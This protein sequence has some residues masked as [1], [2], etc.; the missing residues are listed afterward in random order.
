[1]LAAGAAS[2]AALLISSFCPLLGPLLVALVLGVLVANLPHLGRLAAHSSPRIDQFLLRGGV[3][4]LGL[5]VSPTDLTALGLAGIVVAASTVAITYAATQMAGRPLGIDPKLVTLIAAGFSICG[6][7]AVA[8]VATSIKVKTRDIA[9]TVAL[10]T[11]FGSV[12]IA[13]IPLL[14]HAL[15]LR[16]VQTAIWAGASIHEV[17]QVIVA[18]SLVSGASV[19][20]AITVKLVRVALLAPVQLLSSRLCRE[21]GERAGPAVPAFL[22]GFV[23][24]VVLRSTGLLPHFALDLASVA[25]TL[26]LGAA[27]FGLGTTVM[28]HHLWPAPWRA[29]ALSAIA[30]AV[31]AGSSLALVVL[32][33]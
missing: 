13:A 31:A 25:T 30:T 12:M 27:M 15:G 26:L 16:Q 4:L 8:A 14:G 19:A 23:A 3:V 24:A 2:V 1:V 22:V 18:A 11:V 7:A 17:A 9:L 5:K 28:A 33:C 6:A 32:F 29:V 21:Q 20:T 10:V